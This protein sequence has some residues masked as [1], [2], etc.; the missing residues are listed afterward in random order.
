MRWGAKEA[1]AALVVVSVLGLPT[2]VRAEADGAASSCEATANRKDVSEDCKDLY[3][4]SSNVPDLEGTTLAD[5]SALVVNVDDKTQTASIQL[6]FPR[7]R[8]KTSITFTG[9]VEKDTG[10]AAFIGSSGLNDAASVKLEYSYIHWPVLSVYNLYPDES[11]G[12]F[13]GDGLLQEWNHERVGMCA[14]AAVALRSAAM[15]SQRGGRWTAESQ[16]LYEDVKKFDPPTPEQVDEHYSRYALGEPVGSMGDLTEEELK[17]DEQ[18]GKLRSEFDKEDFGLCGRL[19]KQNAP[20]H[21]YTTGLV[22]RR[23]LAGGQRAAF[24][25]GASATLGRKEFSFFDRQ[26]AVAG[27]L[28]K[29]SEHEGPWKAGIHFGWLF[30]ADRDDRE[31]QSSLIITAS[32]ATSYDS[33][34]AA[35]YCQPVEGLE[36]VTGLGSCQ[37][38]SLGGPK[39]V[40]SLIYGLEYRA[41]HENFGVAVRAF[42]QDI[43]GKPD[44]Y[45]V[46]VPIFLWL[47]KKDKDE[48]RRFQGGISFGWRDQDDDLSV[49][50]FVGRKFE[51]S[52]P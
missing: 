51:L 50:V 38:L 45:G 5:D 14:K 1:L 22:T 17:T 35:Q 12:S 27:M 6:N 36:G 43:E 37:T 4:V 8:H 18:V 26:Q 9:A 47:G 15:A 40:D 3:A 49:A 11:A 44:D 21:W 33:A 19:A 29:T 48:K 7:L 32:Q 20:E 52:G 28:E 24:F 2:Q 16:Q 46:E 41:A 10:N 13:S 39:G 30:L 31:A 42:Y 23:N 34:D 25:A